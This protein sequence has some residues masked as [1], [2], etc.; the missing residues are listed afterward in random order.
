MADPFDETN[1]RFERHQHRI[2]REHLKAEEPEAE[3][4][5]IKANIAAQSRRIDAGL[6]LTDACPDCWVVRGEI[7][8]PH[9]FLAE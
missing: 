3:A 2:A 1:A 6:P 4:N 7:N 9:R 5:A 8:T